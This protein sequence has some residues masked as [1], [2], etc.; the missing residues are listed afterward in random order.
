M[1]SN[2]VTIAWVGFDNPQPLGSHETGAIAALPMW[3]HFMG[4]AL[5]GQPETPLIQPS[6]IV[7]VR[8]NEKTGRP[9]TA[10]DPDAMFE[11][12]LEDQVPSAELGPTDTQQQTQ[13]TDI[14][15]DLF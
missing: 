13:P 3:M 14:T 7:S 4:A 5:K 9:T 1:I 11:Y 12:F 2:I 10:A 15:R 6:G 8:I